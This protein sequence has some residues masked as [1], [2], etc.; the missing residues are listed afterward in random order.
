MST[1]GMPPTLE[2]PSLSPNPALQAVASA[3]VRI[4]AKWFYWIAGLS[5]VNSIV[6]ISGGQ[7]HFVV[8]LGV[9]SVVDELARQ[10]GSAGVVL[11]LVINGLVAGLFALFGYFGC[12]AQKWAFVMGM[13]LYLLDGLL[14]L[15]VKDI[16]SVAFH[17]YALYAIYRG[18]SHIDEAVPVTA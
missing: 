11:D 16:F 4:G 15:M 13:A 1:F 12:K 18:F 7:F 9:T 2:N 10:I 17:A 8:G 5:L 3:R 14:L 6:V